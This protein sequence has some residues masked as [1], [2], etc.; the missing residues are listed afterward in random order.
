M[1]GASACLGG[2]LRYYA[3]KVE[4]PLRFQGQYS[5]VETGLYYNRHRYY[6][7]GCGRFISQEPIALLG[8]TNF[9]QYA[10]NTTRGVDLLGLAKKLENNQSYDTFSGN[11]ALQVNGRMPINKC[12]AEK[13]MKGDNFP[14]N[15]RGK[16]Q[17]GVPF[18]MYGF[19]IF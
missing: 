15:V 19:S 18:D 1:V 11:H 14:P 16:Y 6:D 12:F 10:F 5:H 9:Y 13:V 2:I 17:N 8:G 3:T 7:P 4:Q